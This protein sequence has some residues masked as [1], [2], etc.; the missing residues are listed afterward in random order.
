MDQFPIPTKMHASLSTGLLP[1]QVD[2]LKSGMGFYPQQL[3]DEKE[4]LSQYAQAV[5]DEK[6]TSCDNALREEIGSSEQDDGAI[7][8]LTDAR[9]GCRR[10]AKDTNVVCIGDSTHKVIREEHVTRTDDQCTQRHEL[11]GTRRLYY[12]FD[13][14]IPSVGGPV[15]VH[16]HAHDRNSSVNKFIRDERPDTLN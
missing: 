4:L 8:I 6:N 13:S 2:R 5:Q 11:L 9:H 7:S 12:Y 15:R 3:Q 16:I 10:N 1:S 14:D